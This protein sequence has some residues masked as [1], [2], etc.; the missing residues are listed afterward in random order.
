[1]LFGPARTA[2]EEFRAALETAARSVRPADASAAEG[3][4]ARAGESVLEI[5]VL[6]AQHIAEAD[7]GAMTRLEEGGARSERAARAALDGLA[8]RTPPAGSVHLEAARAALDRFRTASAEIVA[9]S[10]RNS[11]VRSLALS[12][13]RKRQVTTECD[14][15][16]RA[17]ESAIQAHE[18][19]ATR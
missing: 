19:T 15:Q 18:F 9:L 5:Q 13:G 14:E 6:L 12:L 4:A 7:D 10:R 16:L 1:M 2:S 17:L 11:N 3:L 8:A